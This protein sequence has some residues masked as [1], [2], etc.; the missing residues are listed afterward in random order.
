MPRTVHW[1]LNLI[2]THTM[3]FNHADFK[4]KTTSADGS[5]YPPM[6]EAERKLV[7]IINLGAV[8]AGSALSTERDTS[9]NVDYQLNHSLTSLFRNEGLGG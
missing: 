1:N 7:A 3:E 4:S 5:P 6:T 9:Q 2:V 8:V